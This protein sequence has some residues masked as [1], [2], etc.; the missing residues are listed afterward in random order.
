M[1]HYHGTPVSGPAGFV[2]NFLRGRHALVS[3]AYPRDLASALDNC[4]SVV[5]D[6]GAFTHW[7]SG[8]GEVNVVAYHAWV[9]SVA[10]HPALDWCLIPDSID[11]GQARNVAM[12]SEW[13]ELGSRVEGV[14]VYHLDESLDWLDYLVSNFR[15]VALGSSGEWSSPGTPAWWD[16]IAQIMEVACDDA[17]R[18]RCRLHG[19]RMLDP[20]VFTRM[21]LASADSCNA[22]V[23]AGS[24][25]RFG[26]YP[27]PDAW[28]RAADIAAR[29]EAHN[30]AP[31]WVSQGEQ[32]RLVA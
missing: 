26:M 13:Q 3:Y 16:R 22:S 14:P 24:V 8:K 12:L 19:L 28:Q 6:N 27:A 30:S 2:G 32:G 4:Q 11:G 15:T 5:L 21:P 20:E 18:P 7:R 9:E 23:N 1:I 31:V 25:S 29:I 10:G 17:G